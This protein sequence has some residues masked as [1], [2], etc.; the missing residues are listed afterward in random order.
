MRGSGQGASGP[1]RPDGASDGGS[2]AAKVLGFE[3]E[4]AFDDG[5]RD[6]STALLRG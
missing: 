5:M 4:V 6:F 3:A 1:P 2:L